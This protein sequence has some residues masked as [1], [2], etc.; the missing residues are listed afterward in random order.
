MAT[1]GSSPPKEKAN[2]PPKRG[3]IKAQIF[4]SLVKFVASTVTPKYW[5]SEGKWVIPMAM[6]LH[7]QPHHQ[8]LTILIFPRLDRSGFRIIS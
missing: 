2:F 5:K 8:V 4:S 1:N 3:K 7:H 6:A